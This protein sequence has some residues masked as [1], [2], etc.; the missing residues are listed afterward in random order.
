[1]TLK[2]FLQSNC[3]VMLR[4]Y[5]LS[6]YEVTFYPALKDEDTAMEIEV[7]EKYLRAEISYG[8]LVR[9][10]W[11][12]NKKRQILQVL[13]HEVTHIFTEDIKGDNEAVTE[14]LSRLLFKLL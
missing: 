4:T 14:H 7:D 10:M 3:L 12:Q 6:H 2:R 1:M 11:R 5:N 8:K 9:M 13:C